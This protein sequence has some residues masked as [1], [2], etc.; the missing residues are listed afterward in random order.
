[1]PT[2]ASIQELASLKIFAGVPEGILAPVAS[3]TFSKRLARG[4]LLFT[5]GEPSEHL[6]VIRSGAI[7]VLLD[8]DRGD[9]LVFTVLDAG[10]LLGEL[11]AI[12]GLPRS[13][14]AQA[15]R[16]TE[17]LAIPVALVREVLTA[18]PT[19]LFAVAVELAEIL[20]RLSG[21]TADLVFLD[22]PRRLAKLIVSREGA[23]H[24]DVHLTQSELASMLGVTRQSLNRALGGL[25]RRG[26]VTVRGAELH[27]HNRIALE[28]FADS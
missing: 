25:Q 19:A 8:S 1:M 9:E 10:E 5:A 16:P 21:S 26:W 12:D 27:V 20:R 15:I 4:Q 22:L 17:V 2:P 13:A 14:T 11:S 23:G 3:A 7:K 18:I 24:D 28:H 6:Y